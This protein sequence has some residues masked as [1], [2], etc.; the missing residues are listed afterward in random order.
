MPSSLNRHWIARALLVAGACALIIGF[1]DYEPDP[2]CIQVVGANCPEGDSAAGWFLVAGLCLILGCVVVLRRERKTPPRVAS[3][4]AVV[5]A[6]PERSQ[7]PAA[8][9]L[10]LVLTLGAAVWS[11]VTIMELAER[12]Q[13]QGVGIVV[14][15][16]GILAANR[17]RA[18][19]D[20][21]LLSWAWF[22]VIA[23]LVIFTV[24]L[25]ALASPY[26]S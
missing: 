1:L 26:M 21:L 24:W 14:A 7:S 15:A 9:G 10:I 4:P 16:G 6:T 17:A 18:N 5:H 23:D 22:A 3:Q 11:L 2:V 25:F 12:D 13:P 8:L 20:R 19:N